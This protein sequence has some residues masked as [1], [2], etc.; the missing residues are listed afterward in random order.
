[1]VAWW[2]GDGNANDSANG[3][4]GAIIGMGFLDAVYTRDSLPAVGTGEY[5]YLTIRAFELTNSL[6]IA[7]WVN[8]SAYGQAI[9]FRGTA[10]AGL[11]LIK[12]GWTLRAD[13]D[14]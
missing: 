2:R 6:T 3:H 1:L 8:P 14:S 5:W 9:L 12:S 11:I 13:L 4:N 7:A 10:E